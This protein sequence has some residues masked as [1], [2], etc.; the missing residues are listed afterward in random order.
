METEFCREAVCGSSNPKI[1][2][3]T[4]SQL[5]KQNE[6]EN[7]GW[8][9]SLIKKPRKSLIIPWFYGSETLVSWQN[10]WSARTIHWPFTHWLGCFRRE[11]CPLP[12]EMENPTPPSITVQVPLGRGSP[13]SCLTTSLIP[14]SKV[15]ESEGRGKSVTEG[16]TLHDSTCLKYPKESNSGKQRAELWLPGLR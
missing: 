3:D 4:V 8:D 15:A 13:N 14:W 16:Q 12:R 6:L 10:H 2:H 5:V 9:F 11:W 1:L 7:K